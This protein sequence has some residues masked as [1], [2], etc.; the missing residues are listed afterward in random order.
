MKT[1]NIVVIG[2][3]SAGFGPGSIADVMASEALR[4][5]EVTLWLV[6]IDEP[7]LERMVKLAGLIRDHH[8][9]QALVKATTD[10]TE[11]L[12]NADYVITS[13][14]H[15]RWALWQQDFY[16][17]AAY[18]FRQ[19]FGENG[20]PGAAF[21]TLRSLDLMVPI[22]RDME[23]LCPDALLINFTNPESRVIL[24]VSRLTSVRSVGLCHGPMETREK[25]A[26]I[27]ARPEEEIDLVVGGINHFHLALEIKDRKTGADLYPEIDRRIDGFNWNG[28]RFTPEFYRLFGYL[29]YPDPGH[30]GEYLQFAPELVGPEFIEWGIGNISLP[31][32]ATAEDL[33]YRTGGSWGNPAYQ[34]WSESLSTN[35][36]KILSGERAL[37]E[38]DPL[39]KQSIADP[40]WELAVPIIENIETGTEKV[41]LAGNILNTGGA[42]SNLPE[43]AIVEVPLSVGPSGVSPVAVGPLPEA[44]A[45]M[46][47]LQIAIQNILVEAYR[48]KSKNLLL[49]ALMIDP[50]V[51][52]L[53]RAKEM[54]ECMLKVQADVLPEL[55]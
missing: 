1:L 50:S 40:T 36:D 13:V 21:H 15:R 55:R 35:I 51:D 20:G 42:I 16:I 7:A 54:T 17:P 27:L 4:D 5:F 38:E 6:D 24:G 39:L 2:A 11:A 12:K 32:S 47:R 48:A 23:Q 19:V 53:L 9:S 10:R 41:E 33:D 45:G 30:P 26:E 37:T 8:A 49:Q 3:G 18:G 44:H 46:C 29:T 31:K 52:S 14:A 25:I 34:L 28:D 22:A 43:D